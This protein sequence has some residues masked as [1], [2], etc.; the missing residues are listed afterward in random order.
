MSKKFLLLMPIA[1]LLLASISCP[2]TN[3]AASEEVFPSQ[4]TA[5]AM[6]VTQNRTQNDANKKLPDVPQN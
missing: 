3:V 6:T 4:S 2:T 1:L 5:P